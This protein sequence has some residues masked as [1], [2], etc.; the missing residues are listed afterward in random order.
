MVVGVLSD[1]AASR[2]QYAEVFAH[3]LMLQ[4]IAII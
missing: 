1:L 4:P 2:R 3:S